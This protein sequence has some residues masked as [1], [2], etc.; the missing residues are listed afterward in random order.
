MNADAPTQWWALAWHAG[1]WRELWSY[2]FM[3]AAL[4]AML[5]LSVL[6]GYLAVHVVLRRLV[7]IT[8]ALAEFSACGVALALLRGAPPAAVTA[9]AVGGGLVGVIL[10][11][12][13]GGSRRLPRESL[14]GTAYAGA[15]AVSVLMLAIGGRHEG[16]ELSALMWGDVLAL[17]AGQVWVLAAA[18]ALVGAFELVFYRPF[19]LC[20]FD[21]GMAQSV[22]LRVR[23]YDL[24]FHALLGLAVAMAMRLVGMLVVFAYLVMPG[25]IGLLLAASLGGAFLYSIGSAVAGSVSSLYLSWICDIPS[26]LT[27]VV[28]LAV[29]V[30]I[31]AAARRMREHG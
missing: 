31:A 20:G 26:G 23:V 22:G 30:A 21:P 15:A 29:L 28:T 25:V 5:L 16:H 19:L 8:V 27:V 14:I 24:L 12:A 9:Y 13:L 1:Q 7:F 18:F 2:P 11:A 10:L 17:T 3:R 6:G 4:A